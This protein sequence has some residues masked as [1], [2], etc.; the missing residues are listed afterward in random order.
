MPARRRTWPRLIPGL[1]VLAALILGAVAVLA[2]ARV[3]ALHGDTFRLY[4][5]A[6]EARGILKGS[7]VWLAG[8][9][10][11]LVAGISFRESSA[12]T[13]GRLR[14]ALDILEPYREQFRGDSYAQIRSGGSLIGAPV[15]YV[16]PGT[17]AAPPLPEGGVIPG[18]GQ[19]DAED[20]T[21]QIA[22]ASRHVPEIISNVKALGTEVRRVRSSLDGSGRD[23]PGVILRVVGARA[24]RVGSRTFSGKGSVGML[25]RDQDALT[26]RATRVI[27]RADSVLRLANAAIAPGGPLRRDSTFVRTLSDVRNEV[28]IVRALLDQPHGSAGRLTRDSALVQ[29]LRQVERELSGVMSDFKRDPARYIAF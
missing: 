8:R 7:E 14:V 17:P 15:V 19:L 13:A 3:G 10:V 9:R 25:L 24:T 6:S 26:R 2:F 18:K 27:A 5:Y 22:L 11:G 20:V 28:S 16:T 23:E 4:M 21:S 12:D 1:V 29:Q